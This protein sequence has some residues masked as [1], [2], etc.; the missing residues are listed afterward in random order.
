MLLLGRV[1]GL[2]IGRCSVTAGNPL[3]IVEQIVQG[4]VGDKGHFGKGPQK[5]VG[6]RQLEQS[7]LA[8]LGGSA[9]LIRHDIVEGL[10]NQFGKGFAGTRHVFDDAA[11]LGVAA[12]VQYPSSDRRPGS[13]PLRLMPAQT[14]EERSR[15]TRAMRPGGRR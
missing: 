10:Q 13:S 15:Q 1:P 8:I 11:T 7:F 4:L 5:A 6:A 2:R 9:A 14:V 3:H 12:L